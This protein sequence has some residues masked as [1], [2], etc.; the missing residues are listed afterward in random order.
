MTTSGNYPVISVPQPWACGVVFGTV[1][2]VN[3]PKQFLGVG[4]HFVR[5]SRVFDPVACRD[6]AI[7]A[8]VVPMLACSYAAMR[9]R[10][11]G[12]VHVNWC[13]RQEDC[14]LP[15]ADGPWCVLFDRPVVFIDVPDVDW[16]RVEPGCVA[17]RLI[18][19]AS[20]SAKKPQGALQELELLEMQYNSRMVEGAE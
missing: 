3:Q 4:W 16:S 18:E 7:R 15:Y 17:D 5:S 8:R 20:A 19:S 2:V 12:A 10:L 9:D 1:G 14:E 13:V 6:D 11:I